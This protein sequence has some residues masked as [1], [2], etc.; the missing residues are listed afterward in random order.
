MRAT[1]LTSAALGATVLLS[2][3]S[4]R[5][6]TPSLRLEL[7]TSPEA[8]A[9]AGDGT[10]RA[11][12]AERLGRDPFTDVEVAAQRRLRV[13]FGRR[14]GGF[15][16]AVVL[17]DANGA[18]LGT[19]SFDRSGA[20]CEPLVADVVLV[21]AVLLEDLAPRTEEPPPPPA[22][23]PAPEPPPERPAAPAAPPAPARVLRID[24]GLGAGG[25]L[26]IAPRA[27][28]AGEVIAAIDV[29]RARVEGG[30]RVTLPASDEAT[31]AVRS[32]AVT[33]RLAP[34]YGWQVLSPCAVLAI[35]SVRGEATGS[36]VASSQSAGQLY[37]GAGAGLLS[38]VFV[39]GDLVFVRASLEVLAA[40]VRAGFD[41]GPSRAWS[42]P[43]LSASATVGLGVRLP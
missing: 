22:P 19:R 35:G 23:A 2:T 39:A 7:T 33:G 4:A 20:T 10:L 9:C 41:V 6:E 3:A 31:V 11:R 14:P 40:L 25:V 8:R 42:V 1:R 38:R 16:G 27:A 18:R 15:T 28:A 26:G 43:A 30:A 37:A 29:G 13:T 12:V 17:E 24:V 34:C 32:Q 21:V 36:G 5:A